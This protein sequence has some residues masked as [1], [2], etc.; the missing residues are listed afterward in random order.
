[1]QVKWTKQ[2]G[3]HPHEGHHLKLDIS[4]A[5]SIL[6]SRPRWALERALDK[7]ADW[8]LAHANGKNMLDVCL[9]QINGYEKDL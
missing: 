9:E 3:N 2:S 1:M 7:I 5:V 8:H 6:E 4:K